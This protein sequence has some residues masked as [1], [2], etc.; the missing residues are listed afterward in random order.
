[1]KLATKLGV[2]IAAITAGVVM[3]P[4]AA[5]A[6]SWHPIAGTCYSSGAWYT[7]QNVR[8]KSGTS[9]VRVQFNNL[10]AHGLKF[11]IR[12]YNTGLR[13]GSIGY[14]PPLGPTTLASSVT[15]GRLFVNVFALKDGSGGG[16]YN[17]DG[18]EYY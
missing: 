15:G 12:N 8:T 11:Y 13:I 10:P 17:F 3:A 1:M 16:Q 6:A 18:S 14:F 2:T 9:A 7:S 5:F 4:V